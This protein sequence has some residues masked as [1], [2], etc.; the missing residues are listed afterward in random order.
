LHFRKHPFLKRLNQY[1][2][3]KI[4]FTADY[5]TNGV[6]TH[7]SAVRTVTQPDF[8]FCAADLGDGAS[9]TPLVTR[10]GTSN[11][12][13]NAAVNG[14][15]D[16]AGPGVIQPPI[17]ILFH[18]LGASI[19]T[20]EASTN[21]NSWITAWGSFKSATNPPIMHPVAPRD[22]DQ[23]TLRLRFWSLENPSV[24]LQNE[25]WHLPIPVGGQA[26]LQISTNQTD[27]TTVG[28]ASN[29]GAVVEWSHRG[30]QNP[31]KFFRAIP[32]STGLTIQEQLILIEAQR[33]MSGQFPDGPVLPL[34]PISSGT[35][36]GSTGVQAIWAS[37]DYT[38]ALQWISVLPVDIT[39]PVIVGPILIPRTAGQ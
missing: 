17:R 18:K 4:R 19:S 24:L 15:P 2:P 36:G 27:W 9:H 25:T 3:L 5:V 29:A 34:T 8:L 23:F 32:A 16:A 35:L 22:A 37:R 14:N 31:P 39:N 33:I 30:T 21:V 1:P 13:N 28:A 12:V 7:Q 26:L 10:T 20:D 6:V 38:T 11:W